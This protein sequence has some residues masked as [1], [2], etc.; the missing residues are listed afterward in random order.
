MTDV[1][2]Y[3]DGAVLTTLDSKCIRQNFEF[4]M[5]LCNFAHHQAGTN[6]KLVADQSIESWLTPNNCELNVSFV[7]Q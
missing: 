3:E 7:Y 5:N 1:H 6:V 2:V 4:H